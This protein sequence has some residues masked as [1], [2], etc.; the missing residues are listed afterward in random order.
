MS[1]IL[2][3]IKQQ[4]NKAQRNSVVAGQSRVVETT[5]D[6]RIIEN[7]ED[8][9]TVTQR[10]EKDVDY[11]GDHDDFEK[12]DCQRRIFTAKDKAGNSES[13]TIEIQT[14]ENGQVGPLWAD[15]G[16]I[17][18]WGYEESHEKP[19]FNGKDLND[20]N[21]VRYELKDNKE[22]AYFLDKFVI[23]TPE[24]RKNYQEYADAQIA[25]EKQAKEAERVA[26]RLEKIAAR[27]ERIETRRQEREQKKEQKRQIRAQ[28]QSQ[29]AERAYKQKIHEKFHGYNK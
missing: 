17:K 22:I 21:A 26:Q 14:N 15:F 13:L 20:I 27:K 12:Y 18:F 25:K 1:N 29:A 6:A 3:M 23:V 5:D 9:F 24:E 28:F 2:D 7:G 4:K 8:R 11:Y 10:F 16:S 19:N